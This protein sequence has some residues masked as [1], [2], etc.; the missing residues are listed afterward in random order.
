MRKRDKERKEEESKI[1]EGS[2]EERERGG[3]RGKVRKTKAWSG[4]NLGG[5]DQGG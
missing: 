4:E 3:K 1:N 2:G 5:K